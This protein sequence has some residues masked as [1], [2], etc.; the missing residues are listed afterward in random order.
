MGFLL[1]QVMYRRSPL[2]VG[3]SG[4][5]GD[6]ITTAIQKRLKQGRLPRRVHWFCYKRTD[7]D[8]LPQW[9]R[10]R[11][12]KADDDVCFVEA[13]ELLAR[14]IRHGGERLRQAEL[15]DAA[16]RSLRMKPLKNSFVR[17]RDLRPR[18]KR[19]DRV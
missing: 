3:Y 7:A 17:F 15:D 13:R 19:N 10:D 8:K 14:A 5:D 9:L 2:V 12:G 18:S 1:D 11:G 6:V 4:W 16:T